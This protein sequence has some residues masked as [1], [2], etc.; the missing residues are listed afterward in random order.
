MSE[1]DQVC[2]GHRRAGI[3]QSLTDCLHCELERL[4]YRVAV[5][6][7]GPSPAAASGEP[8]EKPSFF[9]QENQC[10]SNAA[11]NVGD[12]GGI[13]SHDARSAVENARAWLDRQ[14][15]T[16]GREPM[17]D[18]GDCRLCGRPSGEGHEPTDPCG[19]V[20]R[21]LTLPAEAQEPW[22]FT[23]E[24]LELVALHLGEWLKE[25]QPFTRDEWVALKAQLIDAAEMLR[26]AAR[27]APSDTKGR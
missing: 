12:Y 10:R 21:L 24:E 13:V 9:Q 17:L 23:R 27:H 5:A 18:Q 26:D 20:A 14:I 8:L 7:R 25:A 2:V 1:Q 6:E 3:M 19:I 16:D 15:V 4:R 22:Q 11:A